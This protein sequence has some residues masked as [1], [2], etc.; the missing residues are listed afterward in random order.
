MCA[1]FRRQNMSHRPVNNA[2][3]CCSNF[4]KKQVANDNSTSFE[5]RSKEFGLSVCLSVCLSGWLLVCPSNAD[6]EVFVLNISVSPVQTLMGPKM[7]PTKSI[8]HHHMFWLWH[9]TL[10]KFIE[11]QVLSVRWVKSFQIS[12][13][14]FTIMIH[15][16]K[17]HDYESFSMS[18]TPM[19][20]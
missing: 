5:K 11:L 14:I 20:I 7:L 3:F 8:S 16:H 17:W 9:L 15:E 6:Y 12:V 4:S 1:R 18:S 10:Y 19:R 13:E 2:Q